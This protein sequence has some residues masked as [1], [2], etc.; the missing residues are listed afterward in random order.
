MSEPFLSCSGLR[1]RF[2]DVEAVAGV[3]L[4]LERGHTLSLVG[5]SGCGKTTLLRIMAGFEAP[6]A[7]EVRLGGVT[8]NGRGVFVP[9]EKRRVGMVFQDYA[10]FPHLNVEANVAFGLRRRDRGRVRGLLALVGL[11]G[12]GRRMPHQLSGGQ[13]QRVALARALAAEPELILLDEPFS[14]LDPGMRQRVRGEVRQL[15]ESL[16][17]TAI[18]VTHD[19]EEALSLAREVAVMLDGRVLQVGRP[20]EV[21]ARPGTLELAAFLGEANILAGEAEDGYVHCE[22][23]RIPL[24]NGESGPVDVMVRPECLSLS[25]DGEPA[26]VVGTEYYGHDQMVVVRLGSGTRLKVRMLPTRELEVGQRCGLRLSGGVV[27]FP[28]AG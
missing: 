18:F 5:P 3:D 11:E 8:L 12:L 20:G 24:T 4:S 27:V 17:T 19:Q 21:Y 16:G 7:G 2:G 10:L 1:R 15:I 6:D 28:R 13:Q 22:L 23:G 26:E 25:E 9:P 14:N